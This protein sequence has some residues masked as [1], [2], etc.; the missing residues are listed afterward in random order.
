M[1]R[2]SSRLGEV[3]PLHKEDGKTILLHKDTYT[4]MFTKALKLERFEFLKKEIGVL[5]QNGLN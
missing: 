1:E 2:R 4:D 3:S 5:T